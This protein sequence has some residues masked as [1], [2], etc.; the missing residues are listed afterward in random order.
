MY[1][2]VRFAASGLTGILIFSL[3]LP[4][5]AAIADCVSAWS[6]DPGAIPV[7]LLITQSD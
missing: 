5:R 6:D 2:R 7:H 1:F 3:F 4:R